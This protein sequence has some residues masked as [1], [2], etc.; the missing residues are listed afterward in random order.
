[1]LKPGAA[2]APFLGAR[3]G[4]SGVWIGSFRVEPPGVDGARSGMVGALSGF[5]YSAVTKTLWFGPRLR[6]RPFRSFF[7]AASGF[8]TIELSAET[9]RVHV[10]EGELAVERLVLRDG[11]G[12]KRLDWKMTARPGMT[13]SRPVES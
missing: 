4:G 12:E 8:G 5:R 10:I 3:A 1:M 7:S 2:V 9:L 6:T 11:D 13:A